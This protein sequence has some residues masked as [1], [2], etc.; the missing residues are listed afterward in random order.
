[1]VTGGFTADGTGGGGGREGRL[2][3]LAT[4][5]ELRTVA[6]GD[7][8][9]VV[10]VTEAAGE[11]GCRGVADLAAAGGLGF[12]SDGERGTEE[13]EEESEV[14]GDCCVEGGGEGLPPP[15]A[16]FPSTADTLPDSNPSRAC[17]FVRSLAGTE[18]SMLLARFTWYRLKTFGSG[19]TSAAV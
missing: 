17:G 4:N 18:L 13:T 7:G 15:D 16:G 11:L 3:A 19:F 6:G 1:M 12:V 8:L 9:V 10:P 5:P 14:E 2:V